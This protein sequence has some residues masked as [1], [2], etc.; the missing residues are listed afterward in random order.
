VA[1]PLAPL[2]KLIAGIDADSYP[3]VVEAAAGRQYRLAT[4]DVPSLARA[5][6]LYADWSYRV[7]H[8]LVEQLRAVE[9]LGEL[10]EPTASAS[11]S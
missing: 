11:P 8:R 3:G 5:W 9:W 4:N 1:P 6:S 7:G 2:A 10:S